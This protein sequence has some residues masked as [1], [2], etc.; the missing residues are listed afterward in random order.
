MSKRNTSNKMMS[1]INKA[2][3]YMPGGSNGNV[4]SGIILDKGL[5]SRVWDIN[6]TEYI[7]YLM[8]SGPML[9]GHSHP[10]VLDAVRT[11][12]GKST[13][14][15]V[16]NEHAIELAEQIVKAVACAE[17]VRFVSSGTEATMY[18][19]RA[20]RAYRGREI[21]LK[22]EGGFHGMNDYAMISTTPNIPLDYPVGIPDSAGIPKSVQSSM[23]VAPFNDIET[24]S[25]II[26]KYHEKIAGVIVE[27]LQRVIPPLPGFL[28]GLRDVT[29]QYNIPL[30]FDEIV[31][32]FRLAYGGAQEYYGVTPDICTLGK[33]VAGGFPLAAVTG[34]DEIM[35]NFSK[36]ET[37]QNNLIPQIGTLSGNPIAAVAGL[38]TLKLLQK[39]GTY[40]SLHKTGITIIKG[41]EELICDSGIKAQVVGEGPIFDLYFLDGKVTNYRDTIRANRSLSK[42]FDN[43]ILDKGIFKG[44]VKYYISTAH[45]KSEVEQTL[46]AYKYAINMMQ[47]LP[48]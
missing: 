3:R 4:Y 21:I 45:N 47:D 44:D 40:E 35:V 1:L 29:I 26:E 36:I 42:E 43:N 48:N 6:G 19:M 46:L 9:V 18:A 32:G 30:I 14:F 16:L 24:T 2:K 8:G 39:K 20:A 22:F 33:V 12:L 41:L 15:F 37:N 25:N 5:G 11:Q 13:T 28:K 31:T 27:P 23:L 38:A 34:I 10:D 7:D 17:K